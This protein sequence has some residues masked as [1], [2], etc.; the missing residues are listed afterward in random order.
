MDY[1]IFL[2]LG[3]MAVFAFIVVCGLGLFIMRPPFRYPYCEI[4]LDVSGKR[5]PDTYDLVDTYLIEN[6]FEH[7]SRHF[8]YVLQWKRNCFARIDRSIL[9]N[10]RQRQYD[11]IVDDSHMF[12]FVLTRNHRRYRQYNYQRHAYTV[13]SYDSDFTMDFEAIRKRYAQLSAINFECPLSQYHAKDQRKL[14]TK[15]L[16][17]QIALRDNYTCRI[18]GKYMPDGVGLQI[19][20]IIPVKKGGKSVPSNLQVLCSKCNGKKSDKLIY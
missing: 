17:T 19:D 6:G 3:A 4:T 16:R 5:S 8:D 20:H 12:R 1:L 14:V 10:L 13:S 7:I 18:C 15:D 9:K 11:R 2:A